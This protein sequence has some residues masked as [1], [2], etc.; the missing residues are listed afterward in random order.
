MR[1]SVHFRLRVLSA[2]MSRVMQ[3]LQTKKLKIITIQDFSSV[4]IAIIHKYE[5]NMLP[6]GAH[7][8]FWILCYDLM[9][10]QSYCSLESQSHSSKQSCFFI[11]FVI[12][13]SSGKRFIRTKEDFIK[14]QRA[15]STSISLLFSV[16]VWMT[17]RK[18]AMFQTH[19]WVSVWELFN[20]DYST[21]VNICSSLWLR[22]QIGWVWWQHR[23][24]SGI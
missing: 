6:Q 11:A 14:M 20:P 13:S 19:H 3:W 10:K 17:L 5:Y 22:G 8:I 16:N 12:F 15:L 23:Q 24:N 18:D 9:Y 7:W 1:L 21:L 2:T 4:N